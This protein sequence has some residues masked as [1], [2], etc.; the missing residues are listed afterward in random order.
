MSKMITLAWRNMWRNWR[1]TTIAL[2]AI[3]LGV[4]LLLFFDGMIKGSDQA[5][6]GNAV[7][8]YGGNLQV[9]ASGFRAKA[10]RLPLLPLDDAEAVLQAARAQPTVVAAARRIAT[11]GI[12][13]SHGNALPVAITAIEPATEAPLSLQAE[14]ITQGRFLSDEDGDAILIGQALA[15]RLE[16]GLGDRVVLLGRS[17]NELMRQ[18]TM[19]IVGI[20][21]LHTPE[22]EKGIVFIPL[23]D[24][25]TLYNLRGQSTEVAIFLHQVGTEDSAMSALQAQLPSY[26]VD[27]W[28]TLR[29]EIR[30][31]LDT[32]L[33]FTSFI[34]IVVLVIAGIGILNL[35]L[36]AVFERTREMGV[37][38]AL[39]MKGRQ[40]MGLF[41]LEG[42]FIG[43]IGAAIG[44]GLGALLIGLVGRVGID[45]S[46]A[47]GMGEV[48]ALL[49]NRL[50]PTITLADVLSRAALVIIIAAVASL[51]PAWQAARKEPAQTL[52]H[53]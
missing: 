45:L 17:K 23:T 13:S 19:T 18:H 51:Y 49:G 47:S 29:P 21:D 8:L 32:K 35:M 38:A 6:F 31:T 11:A 5:I 36:M 7:R 9:H 40:I 33:A 28:Q 50:Y 2:V 44:C 10:N 24:G 46:A 25:Q 42:A 20:Y 4:I 39:G 30:Q 48:M 41:L 26:E 43:V 53:V 3:V 15:E 52:H 14:N 16:V 27:T 37:L 22:I 34:G 12:V 1:R